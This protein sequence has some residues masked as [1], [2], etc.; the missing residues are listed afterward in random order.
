MDKD[1]DKEEAVVMPE[2]EPIPKPPKA[3]LPTLTPEQIASRQR[4]HELK[5]I[6]FLAGGEF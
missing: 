4:A 3:K 6:K 2:P 5:V 1:K